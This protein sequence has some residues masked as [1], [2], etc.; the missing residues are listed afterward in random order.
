MDWSGRGKLV[1]LVLLAM[2]AA[3]FPATAAMAAPQAPPTYFG[4]GQLPELPNG[5][6]NKLGPAIVDAVYDD[7]SL[8]RLDRGVEA[9][10]LL[11]DA[12]ELLAI[13]A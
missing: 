8:L 2:A 10:D 12:R 7:G 6:P 13:L 11:D 9:D 4:T 3:L 1:S 5:I